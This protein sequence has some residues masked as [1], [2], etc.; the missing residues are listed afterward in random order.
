MRSRVCLSRHRAWPFPSSGNV[1]CEF[2][3]M[4]RGA[5]G[6]AS[7]GQSFIHSFIRSFSLPLCVLDFS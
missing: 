5:P 3:W 6:D 4:Q 7:C 2:C 1:A